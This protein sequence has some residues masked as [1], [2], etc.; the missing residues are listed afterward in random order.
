MIAIA[1][2]A[3][4]CIKKESWIESFKKVNIHP[5]TRSNFDVWIRKL[6]DRGF[7][8]DEKFFEKSTTLY[9]AIPACW[10]EIYVDQPQA[11]M[12][13]IRDA[14]N[15]TPSNQGVWRKQKILS[16]AIFVRLE[17]VFKLRSC[18][19][20]AKVYTSVIVRLEEEEY[21]NIQNDSAYPIDQFC[22]WKSSDLLAK[23]Q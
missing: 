9:G 23:Y 3:Q 12:G 20:T 18:Y 10:K 11:V 5:H 2:N 16:L 7:I 17:Y 22:S 14:Y 21:S 4:N 13:I 19:L 8:S 1:V 15:Y 6:D